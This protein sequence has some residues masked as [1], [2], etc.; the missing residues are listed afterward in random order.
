MYIHIYTLYYVCVCIYIYI[1][2]HIHTYIQTIPPPT[3]AGILDKKRPNRRFAAHGWAQPCGG[4]PSER[5]RMPKYIRNLE[6]CPM[7]TFI[8]HE[9]GDFDEMFDTA[10]TVLADGFGTIPQAWTRA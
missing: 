8:D 2:T 10:V 7:H 3:K 5:S 6:I 4:A 9:S 1:Y